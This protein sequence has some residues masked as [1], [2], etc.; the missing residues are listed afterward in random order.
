VAVLHPP[1]GPHPNASWLMGIP[2][3]S[4]RLAGEFGRRAEAPRLYKRVPTL[5]H[6]IIYSRS[7]EISRLAPSCQNRRRRF[8]LAKF[9][10]VTAADSSPPPIPI[11]YPILLPI[12]LDKRTS[13]PAPFFPL[14]KQSV[15]LSTPLSCS[16]FRYPC[17][18]ALPL[19]YLKPFKISPADFFVVTLS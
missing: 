16:P 2:T 11:I 4:A 5:P 19:R 14:I 13:G 9:P 15:A 6:S 18:A 10:R 3:P 8:C 7:L 1:S 12:G 17:P